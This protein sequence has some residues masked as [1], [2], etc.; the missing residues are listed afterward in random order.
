MRETIPL[1]DFRAQYE[2]IRTD[3][4]LALA[5]VLERQD[6]VLGREV[7]QLE[8]EMARLCGTRYAV[9][10][11]SGSDALLLA[12]M[13]L[14]VA[15]GDEVLVPTFTFFATAGAVAR[16]GARPVFTD[17]DPRT[18]N[19]S[20]DS[21]ERIAARHSKIKAAIPVDLFGQVADF[22]SLA[23]RLPANLPLIEDAA[24]AILAKAG[25]RAARAGSFGR[26]G[27][28]SFYPTKNLG[29]Y[30]DA[31]LLTTD[32]EALAGRLRRLRVH[33]GH[34][35]YFHDEV[36]INSRLDTLQAAV[37][38]VKLRRLETWTL[39]RE[40][41]AAR[42]NQAFAEAGLSCPGNV[43]PGKEYPVVA[44]AADE[45]CEVRGA[46]CEE[47]AALPS[48][49]EPRTA[50]L[51]PG[52]HVRHVYH[53]YTTRALDRDR[54]RAF[55]DAEGIR[56]AVFYP[57]PLHLQKCFASLG[58]KPGDCPEAERAAQ[59]VVSLPIFPEITAEQQ[60][61]VVETIARFYAR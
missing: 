57:L 4:A 5:E 23:T 38:L 60:Q 54:L 32:D 21:V 3:V 36:G 26:I 2:S 35:R 8:Q 16:L 30:G 49:L 42:Y 37:L 47:P 31:G 59:E 11:A 58:G 19:L 6:F 46:R 44:P 41:A 50:N 34:D 40:T 12:L 20:P 43:Y 33:G 28:F 51:S 14:D 39:A 52:R 1:Q 15:A 22:D 24:Q 17:I 27:C 61:R 53:Q 7:T 25:A 45:R 29:A 13:A 48:N 56:S 9:A 10:C 18:F 55:L